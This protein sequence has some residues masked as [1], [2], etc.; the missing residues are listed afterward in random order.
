[1]PRH[2]K[3]CQAPLPQSLT[4]LSR[5]LSSLNPLCRSFADFQLSFPPFQKQ[6]ITTLN[7]HVSQLCSTLGG[8]F[9]SDSGAASGF[10][11]QLFPVPW[12]RVACVALGLFLR[13][14]RYHSAHL[15]TSQHISVT[16]NSL[17]DFSDARCPFV[18]I[19]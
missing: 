12:R 9:V 4:A 5:D 7:H 19:N 3:I 14:S 1:M 8:S 6:L 18:L 15:S 13:L 16:L 11:Q 17:M 2:V 10:E